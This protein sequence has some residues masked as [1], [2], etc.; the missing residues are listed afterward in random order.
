MVL[1]SN[2]TMN[3]LADRGTH[4]CTMDLFKILTLEEK[5]GIFE[6]KL[7]QS[8]DV[9]G[10]KE[11]QLWSRVPV[12]LCFHIRDGLIHWHQCK[13]GFYIIGDHAFPFL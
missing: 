12:V 4:G 8:N 11:V 7:Q 3:R 5:I 9:L 13:Q 10:D 1:D 6:A 2:S